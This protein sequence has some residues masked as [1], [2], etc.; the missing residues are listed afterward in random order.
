V[1]KSVSRNSD[2][3]TTIVFKIGRWRMVSDDLSIDLLPLKLI[4]LNLT[5]LVFGIVIASRNHW[6]EVHLDSHSSICIP[7]AAEES[8]ICGG[9]G[10]DYGAGHRSE[11]GD[12]Q[13]GPCSAAGAFALP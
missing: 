8:G 6:T 9:G 4:S 12:L 5:V 3:T 1:L 2:P 13:R 10:V 7:D 11:Y